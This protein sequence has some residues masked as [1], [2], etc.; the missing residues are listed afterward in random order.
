M[1]KIWKNLF[2]NGDK[3]SASEIVYKEGN[4]VKTVEDHVDTIM[5]QK[6]VHGLRIEVV[7]LSARSPAVAINPIV[8]LR[9][10]KLRMLRG[11]GTLTKSGEIV[12]RVS[13]E[14]YPPHQIRFG[15]FGGRDVQVNPEGFISAWESSISFY[16]DGVVWF[17]D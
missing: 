17:V 14:D 7:E 16:L 13:S 12:A 2:G 9:F 6:K 8:L 3:I 11:N 1:K 15:V 5:S 10:G 4:G